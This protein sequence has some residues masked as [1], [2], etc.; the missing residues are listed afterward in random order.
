MK[1]GNTKLNVWFVKKLLTDLQISNQ[2]PYLCSMKKKI[3]Y[4]VSF[5]H[6]A[7]GTSGDYCIGR[8][9]TTNNAGNYVDAAFIQNYL[10]NKYHT[11]VKVYETVEITKVEFERINNSIVEQD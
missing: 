11:T 9:T 5:Y 10:D 6:Y 3:R 7:T 8:L 2:Q 4:F 1:D